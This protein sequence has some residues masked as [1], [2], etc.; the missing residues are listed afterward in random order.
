MELAREGLESSWKRH[1][2]AADYLWNR[3][4]ESGLEL[5]V[6]K[7]YRLPSLTT[8]RIPQGVDGKVVCQ[9]LLRDHQIEIGGGL[10]DL[11]GQVWRIGLMGHNATKGNVDRVIAALRSALN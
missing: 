11:A 6:E 9:K 4:E 2:E 7:E 5:H 8:I 3:L 1:Q 10:G